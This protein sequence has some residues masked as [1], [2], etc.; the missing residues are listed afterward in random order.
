MIIK[1]SNV[2]V[3]KKNGNK[4]N[5]TPEKIKVAISKSAARANVDLA[6]ASKNQVVNLVVDELESRGLT[7]ISVEKLHTMLRRSLKL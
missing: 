3:I 5:F 4:E 2:R 1:D 6:E 7:E